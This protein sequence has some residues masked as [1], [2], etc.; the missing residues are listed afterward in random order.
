M[1]ESF[2]CFLSMGGDSPNNSNKATSM[3]ITT[4]PSATPNPSTSM[5]SI[6]SELVNHCDE[7]VPSPQHVSEVELK[8]LQ[9]CL[10]RWRKEVECNVKRKFF[11]LVQIVFYYFLII[12]I[13]FEPCLNSVFSIFSTSNNFQ[14]IILYFKT[15]KV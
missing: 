6:G 8:V 3:E 13:K 1:T 4:N 12:I 10:K 7:T 14:T 5:N 2:N 15:T 9:S 11:P